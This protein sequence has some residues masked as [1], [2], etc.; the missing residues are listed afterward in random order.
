MAE[1]TKHVYIKFKVSSNGYMVNG[2]I[3]STRQDHIDAW[4][5]EEV[6]EDTPADIES[7]KSP[8]NFSSI[9]KEIEETCDSF[10]RSVPYIMVNIPNII[11]MD[12]NKQ[13]REFAI[14]HG[15]LLEKADEDESYKPPIRY[16]TE[17]DKRIDRLTS[18]ESGLKTL[19]K[20]YFTGLVSAFDILFSKIVRA[21]IHHQ[22]NLISSLNTSISFD[23]L[24]K[25]G[26]V[27]D[28]K[29]HI[30]DKE[31][32]NLLRSSHADQIEWT[33]KRLGINLH[34]NDLYPLF[35]KICERRNL[36]VHTS[37]VVSTQ[38]ISECKSAGSNISGANI[39][40]VLDVDADYYRKSVE[41]LFAYGIA[42]LQIV[43]RKLVPSDI[44]EASD[45]LNEV[46]YRLLLQR[47]YALASRLLRF[48]L[49]EIKK[50]GSEKIR[51][52]MLVNYANSEKLSGNRERAEEILNAE[53]WSAKSDVFNICVS[54]VLDDT[55]SVISKMDTMTNPSDI[56]MFGFREW[57]IFENMRTKVEFQD[58][59][60]IVFGEPLFIDK[61]SAK[62]KP[63][64]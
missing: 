45:E 53:D 52:R 57:P 58:K 40:E 8:A 49:D 50:H 12:T 47:R 59:F 19:P 4:N 48:G 30:V 25:L 20:L 55:E 32:E 35:I 23:N 34:N 27:E 44:E 2:Y 64:L 10:S 18:V 61:E 41:T 21:A 15:I 9:S 33:E 60:E 46:S 37:G 54:A 31:I 63:G 16:I 29:N 42:I 7:N 6:T 3:I 28:A 38:Y 13:V 17:I 24:V 43:W 39:G 5:G 26:S 36:I 56:G 11:A 14:E 1:D 51:L 22:P 62:Q